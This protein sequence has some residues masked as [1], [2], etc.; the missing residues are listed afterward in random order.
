MTRVETLLKLLGHG[1]LTYTQIVQTTGWPAPEVHETVAF[2]KKQ[3]AIKLTYR[4]REGLM[5]IYEINTEVNL[6]GLPSREGNAGSLESIQP[7]VHP[8]WGANHP[9]NPQATNTGARANR[10]SICSACGMDSTRARRGNDSG[11]CRFKNA[12]GARMMA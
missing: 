3:K 5:P 10:E 7:I 6:Q 2:C 4:T 12:C 8:L 11:A 1:A 9:A